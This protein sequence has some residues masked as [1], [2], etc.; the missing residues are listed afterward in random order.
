MIELELV[1]FKNFFQYG[2]TLQ[3]FDLTKI[4][5]LLIYG[6]NGIGKST[7]YEALY[8]NWY[9]KPYRKTVLSQLINDTNL[10]G[11]YTRTVF[12]KNKTKRYELIRGQKPSKLILNEIN[13]DGSHKKDV[14]KDVSNTVFQ[15]KVDKILG[16]D[17]TTF[18]Q[19]CIVDNLYYTPFLELKLGERRNINDRIFD[20]DKLTLM[21]DELKSVR[22]KIETSVQERKFEIS[23]LQEKIRVNKQVKEDNIKQQ[24]EEA[25]NKIEDLIKQHKANKLKSEIYKGEFI[26]ADLS[27]FDTEIKTNQN[28]IQDIK[29]LNDEHS[30]NVNKLTS[31]K[32]ELDKQIFGLQKDIENQTRKKDDIVNNTQ[33][34]RDSIV[35]MNTDLKLVKDKLSSYKKFDTTVIECED[36]IKTENDTISTIRTDINGIKGQITELD[37]QIFG[38]QKDIETENSKKSGVMDDKCDKCLQDVPHTHREAILKEIDDKVAEINSKIDLHKSSIEKFN[39]DIKVAEDQIISHENNI[40]TINETIKTIKIVD[41]YNVKIT[42]LENDIKTNEDE[43]KKSTDSIN[44]IE[45]KIKE[46]NSNIETYKSNLV[47]IDKDIVIVNDNIQKN[48]DNITK[49]NGIISDYNQKKTDEINRVNKYNQ[50]FQDKINELNTKNSIIE[51]DGKTVRNKINLLKDSKDT[52]DVN[53]VNYEHDLKAKQTQQLKDET[54]LANISDGINVLSDKEARSFILNKRLPVFNKLIHK[55][56]EAL[57]TTIRFSF[58]EN[59]NQKLDKRYKSSRPFGSLSGGLRN[60]V[61]NS[62]LFSQL[63]FTERKSNTSF[64]FIFADELLDANGLDYDGKQSLLKIFKYVLNKKVI[65]ISHDDDVKQHF[66]ESCEAVMKGPFASLEWKKN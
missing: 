16:A 25:Q 18:K 38:L 7:I 65:V 1:Q 50:E 4:D 8:Y 47:Q 63:E 61:N 19:L 49:Y 13:E 45:V 5:S 60:R 34:K 6:A 27:S 11:L 12:T 9:N 14:L 22:S 17:H 30:V 43:L 54:M 51:S 41:E 52:E 20:L 59:F 40:V 31:D 53:V 29:K 56:L 2:N 44:D 32:A 64:N 15:E 36:Q 46:F 39:N 66:A 3:E 62:I 58:D 48:E 42:Q 37:K 55:Y 35:S 23:T 24:L 33:F 26:E 10:K 57:D 28:N 21:A